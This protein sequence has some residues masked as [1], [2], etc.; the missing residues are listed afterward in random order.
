MGIVEVTLIRI[1]FFCPYLYFCSY[2]KSV[3]R[4]IELISEIMSIEKGR[5]NIITIHRGEQ[6]QNTYIYSTWCIDCAQE[7]IQNTEPE[8]KT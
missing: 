7:D 4:A 3:S 1:Y 2:K 8:K 5:Q 6:I